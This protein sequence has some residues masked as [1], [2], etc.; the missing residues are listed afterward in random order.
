[1]WKRKAKTDK[2]SP[3]SSPKHLH[4]QITAR[5]IAAYGSEN[6]FLGMGKKIKSIMKRSV[7]KGVAVQRH[8]AHQARPEK[9]STYLRMLQSFPGLN[10]MLWRNGCWK[11]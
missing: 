3:T 9:V 6:Y 8:F 4:D 7:Q 1:L 10:K 11:N 5:Y 2:K